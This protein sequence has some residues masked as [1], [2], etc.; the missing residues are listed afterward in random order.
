MLTS[1]VKTRK[2]TRFIVDTGS[3]RVTLCKTPKSLKGLGSILVSAFVPSCELHPFYYRYSMWT[4]VAGFFGSAM[5]MFATG[6]MLTAVGA[7]HNPTNTCVA[8]ITRWLIRDALG[9]LGGV[10]GMSMIGKLPDI[11]PKA[12][13]MLS[14]GLLN[15]SA[16]IE[17]TSP[18]WLPSCSDWT[19]WFAFG[20]L[21]IGTGISKNMAMMVASASRAH[22]LTWLA[23]RRAAVIG[24]LTARAATQM[25][26]AGLLGTLAGIIVV[27]QA[28]LS[29]L[30]TPF[31]ASV[32][33]ALGLIATRQACYYAW[34]ATLE[35]HQLASLLSFI[36]TTQTVP[37][38]EQFSLVEPILHSNHH[39]LRI[40][41]YRLK[42]APPIE[43]IEEALSTGILKQQQEVGGGVAVWLV[44]G[45]PTRTQ[46]ASIFE[47]VGLRE[48]V[49][50]LEKNGWD[51][52]SADLLSAKSI[53]IVDDSKDNKI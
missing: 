41:P 27:H 46:L 11:N 29:V 5:S 24:E 38:P 35:K 13:R 50:E 51:I 28:W 32:L 31:L 18:L 39:A 7:E 25:T 21:A 10:L 49:V 1:S 9:Q 45:V 34:S 2:M 22:Q 47:L 17:C 4:A 3:R 16:L 43:Q 52:D 36:G 23:P 42:T 19:W 33:V 14:N 48:W 30:T 12:G 6:S 53:Q 40:E 15:F 8:A 20:A 26:A 44:Q 37:T